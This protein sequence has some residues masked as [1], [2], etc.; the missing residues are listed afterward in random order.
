[1]KRKKRKHSNNEC[2][3]HS[4]HSL[5]IDSTT[6]TK[7]FPGDTYAHCFGFPD[8]WQYIYSLDV[9]IWK[10]KLFLCSFNM[11]SSFL[12][13]L[14]DWLEL[15]YLKRHEFKPKSQFRMHSK[16]LAW[17][18]LNFRAEEKKIEKYPPKIF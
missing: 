9:L 8:Y 10:T 13:S 6:Y 2:H 11:M 14:L 3:E 17:Q 7:G 5:I 18:L 16:Y 15:L 4:I 1:M 12:K